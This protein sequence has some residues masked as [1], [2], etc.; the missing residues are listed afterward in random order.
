MALAVPEEPVGFAAVGGV[1]AI[2]LGVLKL[3]R[4][5]RSKISERNCRLN[6]SRIFVS[7]STEKSQVAR[8]RICETEFE[9]AVIERFEI[10]LNSLTK[11]SNPRSA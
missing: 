10:V 6:R 7:F 8:R 3:A 1:K 11:V 2:R 5:S 4:F 9:W